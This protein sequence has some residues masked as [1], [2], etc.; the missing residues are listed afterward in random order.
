MKAEASN[1]LGFL[2]FY[3]VISPMPH[4][5]ASVKIAFLAARPT[6]ISGIWLGRSMF[7]IFICKTLCVLAGY[8]RNMVSSR[9]SWTFIS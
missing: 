1:G 9:T 6:D 8:C 3:P 5:T 4:S 2:F 7:I